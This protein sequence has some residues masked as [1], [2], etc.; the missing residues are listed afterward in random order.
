MRRINHTH[1]RRGIART[2]TLSVIVF[3]FATAFVSSAKADAILYGTSGTPG[4]VGDLTASCS[5]GVVT[6]LAPDIG[7]VRTPNWVWNGDGTYTTT[8]TSSD[9]TSSGSRS[10]RRSSGSTVPVGHTSVRQLAG[11]HRPRSQ[12]RSY[13]CATVVAG[14]EH[15]RV[16]V[17][18]HAVQQPAHRPQV[19]RSLRHLVVPL[20]VHAELFAR[21]RLRLESLRVLRRTRRNACETSASLE[22]ADV[23]ASLAA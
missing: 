4:S 20:V 13:G 2:V 6:A 11:R 16:V 8:S 21:V 22:E 12:H 14:A 3:A 17:G 19:W 1:P 9:R 15:R 18:C 7:A 5:P 23:S 10:E